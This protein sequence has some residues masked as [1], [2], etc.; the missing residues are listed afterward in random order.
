LVIYENKNFFKVYYGLTINGK[1]ENKAV[2]NV[3]NNFIQMENISQFEI[4][5]AKIFLKKICCNG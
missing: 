5:V 3:L 1:E 2:V 4:K